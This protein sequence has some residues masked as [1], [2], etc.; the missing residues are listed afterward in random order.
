VFAAKLIVAAIALFFSV[1][2]AVIWLR[3]VKPGLYQPICWGP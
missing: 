2:V 1:A 3:F